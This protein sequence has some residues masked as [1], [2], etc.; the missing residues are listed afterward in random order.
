[1]IVIRISILFQPHVERVGRTI[2][3]LIYKFITA[4]MTYRFVDKLQ[5]FVNTYNRRKHRSIGLSPND[6]E[7]RENHVSVRLKQEK[8]YSKIKPTKNIKFKVGDL[9]RIA[10]LR[11]KFGRSY[12]RH[13]Q[14][15]I[16]RVTNINSKFPRVLYE[17]STIDT[18]EKIIGSF[19]QEEMTLVINQDTYI[20]EKVLKEKNGK[21]FVKWQGYDKPSWIP[22]T[23]LTQIKD[24]Q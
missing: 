5:E 24:V 8:Y 12:D 11:P 4:N 9:V 10:R 1:M 19:Y 15:E 20:I 21:V 16:F 7:L 17:V 14:E 6:A 23:N 2:Q 18:N 3:G 22:K 13:A